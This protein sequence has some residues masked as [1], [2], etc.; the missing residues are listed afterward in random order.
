MCL[1]AQCVCNLVVSTAPFPGE[2]PVLLDTQLLLSTTEE[3]LFPAKSSLLLSDA[4]PL[5][6]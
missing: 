6:S 5:V 2:L 4:A 1:F 3:G